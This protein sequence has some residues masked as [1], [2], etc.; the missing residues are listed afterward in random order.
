MHSIFQNEPWWGQA[1]IIVFVLPLA[2]L[3]LTET[4]NYL[5]RKGSQLTN[6]VR[7]LRN[8]VLPSAALYFLLT[9]VAQLPPNQRGVQFAASLAGFTFIMF[10]LTILKAVIFDG[11][12]KN[13]SWRT[14]MPK[15]FIDVIRFIIIAIGISL[16]LQFIWGVNV[17]GFFETLGVTAIVVGLALQSV[18]GGI[19]SGLLMQFERPFEVGDYI[20]FA[21]SYGGDKQAGQVTNISWRSTTLD[22]EGNA[23]TVPNDVL[24]TQVIENLSKPGKDHTEIVKANFSVDDNPSTVIKVMQ[25]TAQNTNLIAPDG[26]A[27]GKYLGD[28]HYSVSVPLVSHTDAPAFKGL[29]HGRLWYAAKRNELTLD[30]AADNF[31]YIIVHDELVKYYTVLHMDI[32]DVNTISPLILPEQYA[33]GEIIVE[34]GRYY[35]YLE[36]ITEGEVKLEYVTP[37]GLAF[38]VVTLKSGDYFGEETLTG[39]SSPIRAVAVGTVTI[40]KIDEAIMGKLL[41]KKPVLAQDI[42][43]TAQKRSQEILSVAKQFTSDN[44]TLALSTLTQR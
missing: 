16:I 7:F 13:D 10:I 26:K 23:V 1:S 5:S 41:D 39:Q 35:D 20:K 4:F 18:F 32:N 31:D 34:P 29:F 44:S 33:D 11:G 30:G 17:P 12:D 24:S 21:T 42:G 14:R 27:K 6:P 40:L 28:G 25:E 8:Y 9:H 38:H 36:L 37:E 43:E 19:V 2:I 3:V 22:V 15:I